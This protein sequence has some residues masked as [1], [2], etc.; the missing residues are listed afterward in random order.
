MDEYD[1]LSPKK[2]DGNC[3]GGYKE[4]GR[5]QNELEEND[6]GVDGMLIAT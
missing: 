5:G 2:D 3:T 4:A 1:N 6:E